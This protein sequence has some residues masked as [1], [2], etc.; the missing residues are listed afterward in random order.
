MPDTYHLDFETYSAA[1]LPKVGEHRYAEDPST[2][3][4]LC[5]ISVNDGPVELWDRVNPDDKGADELIRRMHADPDAL[6]Y[7]HNASFEAAIARTLW[8]RTFHTD[9]PRL[10]QWRCT[11]AMCRRVAIPAS[12][13]KAAEFL[14]LT[15][16]KDK[17]GSALIKLFSVPQKTGKF[18]GRRIHPVEDG[19]E[20]VTVA[21]EK[22]T[23][24]AAWKMF[25]EYCRQDVRTEQAI[26]R[27]LR[28]AEFEGDILAGYQFDLR[29]NHLGI[30]VD[31]AALKQAQL[32]VGDYS[33]ELV[34]EFQT[35]TGMVPSQTKALL[36]WF[37]ER[38]YK[39]DNLQA[40][41]MDDALEDD[42][43]ET[44]NP[45]WSEG[46]TDDAKRAL[47][48]RQSLSYA[49]VKK[50]PTMLNAACADGRVRGAIM[51]YGAS[52]TGR[53]SGKIIQPQN[54]KRPTIEGHED[55]YDDIAAGMSHHDIER[56]YG[57]PLEVLASAMRHFIREPGRLFL[58][59]DFAQIE[60]RVLAWIA[61]HHKLLAAFRRGDDL[62]KLTASTIYGVPYEQITKDQRFIGKVAA[63]ACG[64]NGGEAAFAIMAKNYSVDVEPKKAREIVKLYRE[65]NPEIPRL[66][67]AVGDAMKNAIR[68]PGETFRVPTCNV[69][70]TVKR[71]AGHDNLLAKLPSG[72][73]LLYPKPEIRRVVKKFEDKDTGIIKDWEVDEISYWGQHNNVWCRVVTHGGTGVEN[74]CQAITGDFLTTAAVRAESK[75]YAIFMPVHD[76]LLSRYEPEKG[77]SAEEFTSIMCQLPAWAP[78]FPLAAA[79]NIVRHYSKD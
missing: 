2:K 26:H 5:A 4:L 19:A 11:A 35:L 7:A 73:T 16:Q 41:T 30:P 37:K 71:F 1:N 60:A 10:E 9:P 50:I 78:D 48:I 15:E 51:F 46:V 12:L 69:T 56:L 64:Y 52:R 13:E 79:T 28:A 49:A 55:A 77:Q 14:G 39:G 36:P 40:P 33:A 31:V 58:D 22:I 76:Q 42:V 17:R 25:G 8:D 62:Y 74:L 20:L 45:M 59:S 43:E 65:N 27:K 57:P 67:R 68:N 44:P 47:E 63:L 21:G 18:A 61:G 3:I 38:G 53:S 32:L 70:Y 54:F 72:R 75:G 66:W 6:I 24:A 29:M 34:E 23:V